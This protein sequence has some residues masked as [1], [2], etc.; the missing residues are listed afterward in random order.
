M[1]RWT[2]RPR[3]TSTALSTTAWSRPT[4]LGRPRWSGG[5]GGRRVGVDACDVWVALVAGASGLST[6][7]NPLRLSWLR[8]AQGEANAPPYEFRPDWYACAFPALIDD[9]RALMRQPEFYFAF[10]QVWGE[11]VDSRISPHTH[12]RPLPFRLACNVTLLPLSSS[13]P[14]RPGR[15]AGRTS[16]RRSSAPWP[17]PTSDSSLQSTTA[18][19]SLLRAR[20]TRATSVR[21]P[22]LYATVRR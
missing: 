3:R 22:A 21:G 18:T 20:T 7:A 15:T 14:S 8:A 19:R 2:P 1:R 6:L 11:G 9:W 12:P 13:P 17:C 16:D 10:V 4:R 5:S